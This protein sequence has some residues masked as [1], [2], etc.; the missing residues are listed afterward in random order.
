M[1]ACEKCWGDAFTRS[2]YGDKDQSECYIEI[3]RERN[4]NPCTPEEQAGQWWDPVRQVNTLLEKIEA[5]KKTEV[6]K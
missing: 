4:N 2:Y 5:R 6:P 1:A 3:L